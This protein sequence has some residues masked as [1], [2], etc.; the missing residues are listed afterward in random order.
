MPKHIQRKG[1]RMPP[2]S[3]YVG[4]PTRWRRPCLNPIPVRRN[5]GFVPRKTQVAL[6]EGDRV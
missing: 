3:V 4:Q 1:W 5:I 2:G 6:A